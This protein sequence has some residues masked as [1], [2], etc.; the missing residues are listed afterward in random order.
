[1]FAVVA[2]TAYEGGKYARI[3]LGCIGRCLLPL[4]S[5]RTGRD[6]HTLLKDGFIE[7]NFTLF[8]SCRILIFL[9]SG[10]SASFVSAARAQRLYSPVGLLAMT[11]LSFST[12]MHACMQLSPLHACMHAA[13]T[14]ACMHACMHACSAMEIDSSALRISWRYKPMCCPGYSTVM[15]AFN[16]SSN[17]SNS[18]NGSSKNSFTCCG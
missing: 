18:T 6:K 9:F 11:L 17:S 10:V 1:M 8:V 2:A 12:C 3:K 16:R 4:A 5:Y 13:I 14:L 15:H 7:T